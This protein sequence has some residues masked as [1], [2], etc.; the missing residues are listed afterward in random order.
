MNRNVAL[1][2]DTVLLAV[3]AACP[4]LKPLKIQPAMHA[5][6]RFG[7]VTLAHRTEPAHLAEVRSVL[8]HVLT[9]AT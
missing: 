7:L 4:A 8:T 9:R 5:R 1:R 3:R 2:S 6:A